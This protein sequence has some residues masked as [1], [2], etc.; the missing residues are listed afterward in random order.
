MAKMLVR[1][2]VLFSLGMLVVPATGSKREPAEKVFEFEI[3]DEGLRIE[4]TKSDDQ[5]KIKV[6]RK[7]SNEDDEQ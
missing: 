5:F 6:E 4:G 2:A 1:L 7:D 3:G